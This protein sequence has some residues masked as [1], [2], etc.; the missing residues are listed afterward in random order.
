[1]KIEVVELK[2][3]QVQNEVVSEPIEKPSDVTA[4]L[5]AL[6]IRMAD[7]EVFVVLHLNVRNRVIAHEIIS[8]GSQTASLVP[9][10]YSS[11]PSSREPVL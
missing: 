8:I 5:D 2:V 7:R 11:P 6:D 4:Y 9:A 1:M 10:K 3:K